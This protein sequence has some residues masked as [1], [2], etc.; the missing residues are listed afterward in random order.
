[1]W[2]AYS[3]MLQTKHIKMKIMLLGVLPKPQMMIKYLYKLLRAKTPQILVEDVA[4]GGGTGMRSSSYKLTKL[5][6]N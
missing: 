2:Y 5:Q 6:V 1:M 4:P 3:N